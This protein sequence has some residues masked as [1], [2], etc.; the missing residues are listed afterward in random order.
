MKQAVIV[1][2]A[3]TGLAKSYR[4]A[5]NETHGATMAGHVIEHAVARAGITP[6]LLEDAF[7]GCGYPEGWTGS[8][9]ARQSV[10][11]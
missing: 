4:G 11:R 6:D 3:R 10:I 2:T 8:N 1:S 5:F 7:L 9:I